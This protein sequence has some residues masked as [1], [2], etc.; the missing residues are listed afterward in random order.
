MVFPHVT[1]FYTLPTVT[2]TPEVPVFWIQDFGILM[3]N[4]LM[5]LECAEIYP[6]Y[7]Q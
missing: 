1:I 7:S 2:H 6:K 5:Q 4:T 3:L